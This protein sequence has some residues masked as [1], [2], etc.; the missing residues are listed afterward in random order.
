VPSL[1]AIRIAPSAPAGL[2]DRDPRDTLDLEDKRSGKDELAS[3]Q[4]DMTTLQR[5]LWAEN[6]R[7]ILLVLQ[8][9]DTAGKDSTIRRVLGVMNPHG[10]E[11]TGFGVPSS[12]ERDHDYLWRIHRACPS[13][14][15]IGVFNRSHYEDVGVVRVE[16]LVDD[17]EA[18][19]RFQQIRDFEAMLTANGTT[20]RKVWLHISRDE[21]RER[22]QARV[23]D[24]EKHWK[25]QASDLDHRTRWDD[26]QRVYTEAI[27][28]TSTTDCPWFVVP[29]DRKWV[30]DVAV[31]R[32][33]V[34]TLA[35]MDPK[36]PP[37]DP[38]LEG[39]VVT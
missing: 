34:D 14:G 2:A 8:G 31:A 11:V 1:D 30:R 27:E 12:E 10:V 6:A 5:R 19:R 23:D 4:S 24:P 16:G 18:K 3:L 37:P 9:M 38:T 26:Y 7:A 29:A 17:G 39:L 22:L 21:Q 36:P 13:R 15:R 28:A 33:L 32:I 20:V 25:F 35:G